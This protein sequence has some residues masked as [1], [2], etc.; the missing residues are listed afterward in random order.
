MEV[1]RTETSA[2]TPSLSP[3][4]GRKLRREDRLAVRGTRRARDGQLEAIFIARHRPDGLL[5][6]ADAT[7]CGLRREQVEDGSNVRS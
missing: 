5:I 1:R 4:R 6:G 7:L 3:R 2:F